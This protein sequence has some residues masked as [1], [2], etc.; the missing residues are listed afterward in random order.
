M[1]TIATVVDRCRATTFRSDRRSIPTS[2]PRNTLQSENLRRLSVMD[3]NPLS[4]ITVNHQIG[5][6]HLVM[7]TSDPSTG[8]LKIVWIRVPRQCEVLF[9]NLNIN[10]PSVRISHAATCLARARWNEEIIFVISGKLPALVTAVELILDSR[11]SLMY[12]GTRLDATSIPERFVV[13]TDE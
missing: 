9:R 7:R 10:F 4:M 11:R 1:T 6:P 5:F 8:D 13:M 3:S 12:V 2:E